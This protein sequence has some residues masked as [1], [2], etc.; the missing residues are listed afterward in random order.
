MTDKCLYMCLLRVDCLTPTASCSTSRRQAV[1]ATRQPASTRSGTPAS[2]IQVSTFSRK[3]SSDMSSVRCRGDSSVG[4][5]LG[6]DAAI[7]KGDSEIR[8]E[9]RTAG[10]MKRIRKKVCTIGR[11]L[12]FF[13]CMLVMRGVAAE[14]RPGRRIK[15]KRWGG[16]RRSSPSASSP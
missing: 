11:T 15:K 6:I 8:Y 4:W 14:G 10:G 5:G 13:G 1:A 7:R 12:F 3:S 2:T 16:G 9:A